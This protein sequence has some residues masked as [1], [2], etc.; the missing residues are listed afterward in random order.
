[1]RLGHVLLSTLLMLCVVC[2][3]QGALVNA[4]P[5][6]TAV[7]GDY[8]DYYDVQ[9]A[10]TVIG[11]AHAC[12]GMVT[13]YSYD[14]SK[15]A[16]IS[17]QQRTTY[18]SLGSISVTGYVTVINSTGTKATLPFDGFSKEVK[19]EVEYHLEHWAHVEPYSSPPAN[20][21][22][23]GEAVPGSLPPGNVTKRW[24]VCRPIGYTGSPLD[25]GAS[26]SGDNV[27][28]SAFAGIPNGGTHPTY[29]KVYYNYPGSTWTHYYST[30][31]S[32]GV[33]V[34]VF[35]VYSLSGSAYFA[36]SSSLSHEFGST[37]PLYY[38]YDYNSGGQEWYFTH[39]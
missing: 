39:K 7:G 17:V 4:A 20:L 14:T 36:S 21:G 15:G 28:A 22:T 1:M 16:D 13:T 8:L 38:A 12:P 9:Y 32:L 11:R 2:W 31:R 19:A 27:P 26:L 34:T 18:P 23:G 6:P 25:Y 5:Y 24:D 37:Y 30:G 29:G 10:F 3:S 33:V 35:N